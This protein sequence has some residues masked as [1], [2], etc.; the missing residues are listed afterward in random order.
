MLKRILC[1]LVALS[2][3]FSCCVSMAEQRPLAIPCPASLGDPEHQQV[4]AELYSAVVQGTGYTDELALDLHWPESASVRTDYQMILEPVENDG[5]K[6]VYRYRGDIIRRAFD[7]NG[8]LTQENWENR[9]ARGE[10]VFSLE[11]DERVVLRLTDEIA[12]E[13]NELNL[14]VVEMPAPTADDMAREVFLPLAGLEDGSAGARLKAARLASALIRFAV[15][16][17]LYAV[18]PTKLTASM[19]ESLSGLHWS[20]DQYKDFALNEQ[21]VSGIINVIAGIAPA[22]EEDF[23]AVRALMEDAGVW[24][25]ITS[26]Q[27][28]GA[29]TYSVAALTGQLSQIKSM[30]EG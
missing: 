1:A 28:C 29:D 2:A 6:A 23:S 5:Q 7:E 8:E 27:L 21:A 25:A 14:Q 24:E 3:L 10:A 9:E 20:E 4:T 15:Q 26:L 11:E 13:L 30:S 19:V 12:K 16:S 17:R 22:E 18:N